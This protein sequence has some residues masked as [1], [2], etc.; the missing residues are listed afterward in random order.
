M[1]VPLPPRL[2]AKVEQMIATDQYAD[3]GDVIDRALRPLEEH[4]R[5]LA[6]LRAELALGEEEE[7]RGELIELTPERFEEIERRALENARLGKPIPDA[8]K[9]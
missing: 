2:A 1:T 8:G 6:W 9:P 3:A 4:E 7:A 5:R